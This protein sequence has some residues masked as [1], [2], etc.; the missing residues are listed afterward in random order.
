MSHPTPITFILP[1]FKPRSP[2]SLTPS[3]P[4]SYKRLMRRLTHA[5]PL[6]SNRHSAD[7]SNTRN[8]RIRIWRRELRKR[9][10]QL[11]KLAKLNELVD[12]SIAMLSERSVPLFALT[13]RLHDI[14]IALPT[15]ELPPAPAY[16]YLHPRHPRP[17]PLSNDTLLVAP[18]HPVSD[19]HRLQL[20]NGLLR[21]LKRKRK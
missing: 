7:T 14:S 3:K 19:K 21:G 1:P 11:D 9:Q 20:A 2:L 16:V 5:P 13:A 4:G 17:P 10:R 8:A 12:K 18:L 15:F 6:L